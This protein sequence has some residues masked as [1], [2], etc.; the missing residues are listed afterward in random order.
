MSGL[1]SSGNNGAEQAM[2][3]GRVTGRRGCR[4]PRIKFISIL[5]LMG[6][7][8][9]NSTRHTLSANS[10]TAPG[11]GAPAMPGFASSLRLCCPTKSLLPVQSYCFPPSQ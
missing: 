6:L 9:A 2:Q 10:Q 11:R 3:K 5:S 1:K 7:C 4:Q 8:L